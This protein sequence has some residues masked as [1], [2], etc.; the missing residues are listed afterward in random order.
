MA[1]NVTTETDN[2]ERVD[3]RDPFANASKVA[4]WD[5]AYMSQ[6]AN[7]Y[8]VPYKDDDDRKWNKNT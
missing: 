5:R 6:D 3:T 1:D 8:S 4:E 2:I 7:I